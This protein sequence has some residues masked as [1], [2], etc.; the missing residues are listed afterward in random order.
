[1]LGIL[2]QDIQLD[3]HHPGEVG[4]NDRLHFE[5]QAHIGRRLRRE[6]HPQGFIELRPRGQMGGLPDYL[7]VQTRKRHSSKR[8][9]H[10]HR[11]RR[12]HVP[13]IVRL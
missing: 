11:I 13:E 9:R 8:V 12:K 4:E 7:Q 1:V 10:Q 5:E 6:R 2:F 3:L